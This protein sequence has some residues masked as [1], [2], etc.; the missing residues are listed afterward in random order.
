MNWIEI[1]EAR[2]LSLKYET[3]KELKQTVT[4]A[5][6]M[7]GLKGIEMYYNASVTTDISIHVHWSTKDDQ[8]RKSALGLR[9]ASALTEF[10]RVN[11]TIWI[12]D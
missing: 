3:L 2:S 8:I 1:I 10:G 7:E 4:E 6:R 11:H 12:K 5:D 9:L